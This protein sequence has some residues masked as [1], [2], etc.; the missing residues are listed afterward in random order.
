MTPKHSA[1]LRA[2][3]Q[4]PSGSLLTPSDIPVSSCLAFSKDRLA[5][6]PLADNWWLA[7]AFE[8]AP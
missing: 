6:R 7:V 4:L 2:R 1:A 8:S 3:A 5:V